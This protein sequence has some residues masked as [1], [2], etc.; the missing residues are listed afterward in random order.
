MTEIQTVFEDQRR[1]IREV[2]NFSIEQR[3]DL[4]KKLSSSIIENKKKIQKALSLDFQKPLIET[5]LTEVIPVISEINYTIK[6]LPSWAKE[7]KVK[8]PL[9]YSGTKSWIRN[10]PKGNCLIISPWNYPFNLSMYPIVSA[11]AAG[12]SVILKPSEF[13]P[14]TNKIIKQIITSVFDPWHVSVIEG[15]VETSQQLLSLPFDHIFFTGSTAVGKLVMEAASKHLSS[16]T[17]EL[18]GK[19]P[20]LIDEN[21]NIQEAAEKIVWGKFLNAGQTCIAPDYIMVTPRHRHLFVRA[22]KKTIQK[23]YGGHSWETHPDLNSIISLKHFKR[24]K[25]LVKD[26]LDKGAELEVGGDFY[27]ET[28]KVS[29]TILVNPPEDS[30]V[31]QEEIFGPLLPIVEVESFEAMLEYV[32]HRDRPLALYIFSDQDSKQ[33]QALNQTYSGGVCINE[34]IMHCG[35][36]HL[37][38]GGTGTSGQGAYHGLQGFKEFSHQRSVMKRNRNMGAQYFYPP[39]TKRKEGLVASLFEKFPKLF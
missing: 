6:K 17:L 7:K 14:H 8:T 38:F 23:F 27:E 5:D 18:G 11:I 31:M 13:T 34:V 30:L 28:L 4:L 2:K 33:L 20:V 1:R 10:D 36:H 15:E 29:P 22:L 9:L 12:N 26:A 35:N 32:N 24:L 21:I 37:P 16:V 3:I 39:Y 19:S 25:H